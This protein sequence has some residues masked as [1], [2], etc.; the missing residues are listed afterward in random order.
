VL[1]HIAGEIISDLANFQAVASVAYVFIT[2]SAALFFFAPIKDLN[3]E[4]NL[5]LA[6]RLQEN[7]PN[8]RKIRFFDQQD[9][10]T[11]ENKSPA[12]RKKLV[13]GLLDLNILLPS[14][15][16]SGP[17]DIAQ[18]QNR[19]AQIVVAYAST[20][21]ELAADIFLGLRGQ[22]EWPPGWSWEP[23]GT[24]DDCAS[25]LV[26]YVIL[27][28]VYPPGGDKDGYTTAGF[29]LYR[30]IRAVPGNLSAEVYKMIVDYKLITR[31]DI[32]DELSPFGR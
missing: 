11:L 28:K 13:S 3:R 16:S 20:S 22:L 6:T 2:R 30:L 29:L 19:L 17:P 14:P 8:I 27:Q 26:K 12:A 15:S 25:S 1:L 9:I 24:I 5:S 10:E 7:Y 18:I 32:L 31:Q 4:Y 21:N 23:K